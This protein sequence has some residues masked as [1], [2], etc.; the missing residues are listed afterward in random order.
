MTGVQT[1]ALPI[2]LVED[3][4][5]DA[6]LRIKIDHHYVDGDWLVVGDFKTGKVYDD[7]H[8]QLNLYATWTLLKMNTERAKA[9]KPLLKGARG[10]LWYLDQQV[11]MRE[12][13]RLGNKLTWTSGEL[14]AAA[15]TWQQRVEPMFADRTFS[16]TPNKY[17][18][19]CHL[20]RKN[21]GKCRY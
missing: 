4:T 7:H 20:S 17:C 9:K 19:N 13:D 11:L 16:P 6:W 1:C 15:K 3:G 14:F 2:Y 8:E 12:Q 18:Y 10:E 21:G 5:P